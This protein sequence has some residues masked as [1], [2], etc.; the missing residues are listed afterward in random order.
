[1]ETVT[2]RCEALETAGK[3]AFDVPSPAAATALA[4]TVPNTASRHAGSA[5]PKAAKSKMGKSS[6]PIPGP[7]WASSSNPAPIP[8][9]STSAP[10]GAPPGAPEPPEASWTKVEKKKKGPAV[11]TVEM[12]ETSKDRLGLLLAQDFKGRETLE[13][14]VTHAVIPLSIKAQTRPYLAWRTLLVSLTGQRPLNIV[15]IHPRRAII[16]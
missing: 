1:M 11:L 2:A 3:A 8:S 16:Y 15:L 9:A 10:T 7:A 13:V 4:G 12:I 5:E 6:T 14:L